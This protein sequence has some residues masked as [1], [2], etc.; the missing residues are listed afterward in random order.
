MLKKIED[1]RVG[2][3]Q[4][5]REIEELIM[6]L[7]NPKRPGHCRGFAVVPW[8]FGLGGDIA[9]YQSRRR[10]R[11]REEEEQRQELGKRLKEHEKS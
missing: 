10:R 11:E 2:R 5:D 8:K 9:T 7:K 1:V 4:V 6:A 3:V